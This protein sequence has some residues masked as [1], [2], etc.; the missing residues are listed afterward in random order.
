MLRRSPKLL[1][2]GLALMCWSIGPWAKPDPQ[3]LELERAWG[4]LNF[5]RSRPKKEREQLLLALADRVHAVAEASPQRADL[6]TLEAMVRATFAEVNRTLR[7]LHAVEI[8]RDL[9]R[10]A[11][12]E[13][14][15]E[16]TGMAYGLL[17]SI[18]YNVPGWPI[19][20]G[21][22]RAGK[23]Y[24]E[25]AVRVAPQDIDALYFYAEFL[26]A[27]GDFDGA[28]SVLRRALDAPVRPERADLDRNRKKEAEALLKDTL[29]RR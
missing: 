15:R 22:K 1:I 11:I 26:R 9:L 24:L 17:G 27:E 21:D 16:Y 4:E 28:E 13:G 8:A 25:T 19:A 12:Q 10:Q 6:L 14:T 7:A 3:L 18:Y 2:V 23:T 29:A 5:D 20:W